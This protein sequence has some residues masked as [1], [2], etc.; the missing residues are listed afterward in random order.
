M[1][2]LAWPLL[3][4]LAGFVGGALA[5]HQLQMRGLW[6]THL[7]VP[8][9]A[10]LWLFS[11]R[12]GLTVRVK[13]SAWSMVKAC[14]LVAA[15]ARDNHTACADPTRLRTLERPPLSRTDS[16]ISM[17]L[18]CW[19]GCWLC[20]RWIEIPSTSSFSPPGARSGHLLE[21]AE[22]G[23]ESFHLEGSRPSAAAETMAPVA[24]ACCRR[25]RSSSRIT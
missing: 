12:P 18:P 25:I 4:I 21:E 11:S 14:V 5:A 16:T 3:A 17:M 22:M 19:G 8:D 15:S 1:V 23:L 10:R 6:A 13:N 7:I 2:G 9:P 24:A 20:V